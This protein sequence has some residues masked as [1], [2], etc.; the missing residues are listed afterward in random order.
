MLRI[1]NG[2]VYD[3]ANNLQGE[4][5]DVLIDGDSIVSAAG[6]PKEQLEIGRAHV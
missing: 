4:V 5:R 2:H 3:P 6:I 1:Y